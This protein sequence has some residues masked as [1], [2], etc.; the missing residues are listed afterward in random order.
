MSFVP[1]VLRHGARLQVVRGVEALKAYKRYA[2]RIAKDMKGSE[3]QALLTELLGQDAVTQRTSGYTV[4][5]VS[6]KAQQ[7]TPHVAVCW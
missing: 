7:A 2:G 6:L 5:G 1:S 3:L 4:K